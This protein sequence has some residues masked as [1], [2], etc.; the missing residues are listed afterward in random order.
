MADYHAWQKHLSLD[1]C[2]AKA[3]ECQQLARYSK[4]DD[5]RIMLLKM[6]ERWLRIG[7]T[8]PTNSSS[9]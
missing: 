3:K 2:R 6:A 7:T 8:L 1:E 5:H 9:N 4:N